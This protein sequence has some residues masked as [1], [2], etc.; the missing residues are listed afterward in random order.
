VWWLV[1]RRLK[2]EAVEVLN[3]WRRRESG[4]PR[5]VQS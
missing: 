2:A 1:E 3:G 4:Q 5:D